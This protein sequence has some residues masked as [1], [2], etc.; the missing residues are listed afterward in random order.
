MGDKLCRRTRDG[1]R[2]DVKGLVRA[3]EPGVPK[4]SSISD[5]VPTKN[6]VNCGLKVAD[7]H[8]IHI[9]SFFFLSFFYF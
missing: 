3:V 1:K 4:A 2:K 8:K 9:L 5:H 7:F 6:A